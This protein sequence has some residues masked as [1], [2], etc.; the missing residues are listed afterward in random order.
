[1]AGSKWITKDRHTCGIVHA[2]G[3][4]PEPTETSDLPSAAGFTNTNTN[5]NTNTDTN[6]NTNTVLNRQYCLKAEFGNVGPAPWE[7]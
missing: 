1:M 5:S 7:L 2:A 6:T 4:V 3:A